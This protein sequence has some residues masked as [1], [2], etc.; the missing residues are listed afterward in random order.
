MCNCSK[1]ARTR[2]VTLWQRLSRQKGQ[3]INNCG[4]LLVL[5]MLTLCH[6]LPATEIRT[7]LHNRFHICEND[8][9]LQLFTICCEAFNNSRFHRYETLKRYGRG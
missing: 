6:S 1:V 9:Y 4:P 2:G 7:M 5:Q 3:Q 8:Y